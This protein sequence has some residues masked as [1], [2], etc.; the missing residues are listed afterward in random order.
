[1]PQSAHSHSCR[2][3]LCMIVSSCCASCVNFYVCFVS[4][5]FCISFTIVSLPPCFLCCKLRRSTNP[6]ACLWCQHVIAHCLL[7]HTCLPLSSSSY[8]SVSGFHHS[9]MLCSSDVAFSALSPQLRLLHSREHLCP[10]ASL[11][12]SVAYLYRHHLVLRHTC[13]TACFSTHSLCSSVFSVASCSLSS[14]VCV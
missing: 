13:L 5:L 12:F 1:M 10:T 7:L 8:L 11:L 2:Y 3:Y 4:A 9:F 6:R 14:N